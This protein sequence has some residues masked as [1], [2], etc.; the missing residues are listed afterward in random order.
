MSGSKGSA[1]VPCRW[2]PHIASRCGRSRAAPRRRGKTPPASRPPGAPARGSRRIGEDAVAGEDRVGE[3]RGE[4]DAVRR[5]VVDRVLHLRGEPLADPGVPRGVGAVGVGR[6]H[7]AHPWRQA[8]E[9]AERRRDRRHLGRHPVVR[10]ARHDHA[11][12]AGEVLG[13]AQREVARLRSRA[14]V[15]HVPE[16]RRHRREQLLGVAHDPFV[17][18]ARV[19]VEHSGLLG[20]RRRHARVRVPERRDVVVEVEVLRTVGVVEVHRPRRAP[21]AAGV[22]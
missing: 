6:R 18:V 12:A 20:D 14:R 11:R 9:A 17:Q 15:H 2:K 7:H 16:R 22:R 10:V 3:Q 21:R 1:S 8:L 5:E 19:R 4:A 13:D